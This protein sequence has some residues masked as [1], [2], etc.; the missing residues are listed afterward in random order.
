MG[1]VATSLLQQKPR[2]AEQATEPTKDE[3]KKDPKH[4]EDKKK[5]ATLVKQREALK[6]EYLEVCTV[7][8][9]LG[10]GV[11]SDPAH[12]WANNDKA[13]SRFKE[14]MEDIDKAMSKSNFNAFYVCSNLLSCRAEFGQDLTG[15][16]TGFVAVS[17]THLTLPTILRV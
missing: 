10:K 9:S 17:Y 6:N 13:K 15:R 14:A 12:D 4:E 8:V 1:A 16:L 11:Q 7:Q 5:A 3:E 2:R